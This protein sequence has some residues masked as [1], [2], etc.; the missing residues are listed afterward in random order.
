MLNINVKHVKSRAK[1]KKASWC[2]DT[3]YVLD[4]GTQ[5]FYKTKEE[6]IHA[7][8]ELN[9][10]ISPE[11]RSK[12]TWKWTF[13]ELQNIYIDRVEREWKSGEKSK[14]FYVDKERHSR[15]FLALKIEGGVVANM[16]VTD[17]TMGMVQY[18]LM[19]QLKVAENGSARSRKCIE[20]I[21]QRSWLDAGLATF[22]SFAS[23]KH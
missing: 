16:L 14:T 2:V 1:A 5:K 3:R 7:L 21:P 17:L 8:D 23:T 6:A 18:D 13:S 15:Q 4:D 12:D 19:D 9:K 10:V 11:A 22:L 20:N